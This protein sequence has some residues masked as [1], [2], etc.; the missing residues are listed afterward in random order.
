M[1]LLSKTLEHKNPNWYTYGSKKIGVAHIMCIRLSENAKKEVEF[2]EKILI[3][4]W[5]IIKRL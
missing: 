2:K 1:S 5:H 3:F 4:G